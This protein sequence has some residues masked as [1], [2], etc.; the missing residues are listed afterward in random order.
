MERVIFVFPHV[1]WF[2][3][4]RIASPDASVGSLYVYVLLSLGYI[5]KLLQYPST[6]KIGNILSFR[7]YER[8]RVSFKTIMVYEK[9]TIAILMSDMLFEMQV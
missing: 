7:F 2:L 1:S 5:S 8:D 3:A 4:D 9:N 6:I